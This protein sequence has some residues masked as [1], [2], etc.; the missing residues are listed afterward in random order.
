MVI[1]D[2]L[3]KHDHEASFDAVSAMVGAVSFTTD[4]YMKT[5]VKRISKNKEISAHIKDG[6]MQYV[7]IV[8][9][10]SLSGRE[11][12]VANLSNVMWAIGEE[13][14]KEMINIIMRG[15]L[16]SR[17][18][19]I[20]AYFFLLASG[21]QA[22]VEAVTATVDSLGIKSSNDLAAQ[23]IEVCKRSVNK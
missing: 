6:I 1:R 18:V 15:D 17:G 20:Y 3:E 8:G 23:M 5:V 11:I 12:T 21:K 2:A 19:Y 14:D 9:L 16:K 22:T 7:Y 10:L 13:P 4:E